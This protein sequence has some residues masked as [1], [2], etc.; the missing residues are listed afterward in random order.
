[1]TFDAIGTLVAFITTG[2][3]EVLFIVASGK[4][5]GLALMV[6]PLMLATVIVGGGRVGRLSAKGTEKIG[7]APVTWSAP[8]EIELDSKRTRPGDPA[9]QPPQPPP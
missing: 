9:L 5:N 1:M 2:I 4:L 8:K 7:V 6:M 3:G